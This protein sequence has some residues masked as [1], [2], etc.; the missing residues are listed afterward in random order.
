MS[1]DYKLVPVLYREYEIGLF[2]VLI[3]RP[4]FVHNYYLISICASFS[5]RAT[6]S[7]PNIERATLSGNSSGH[8]ASTLARRLCGGECNF[9]LAASLSL[10][11]QRR[12]CRGYKHIKWLNVRNVASK[13][14]QNDS[15]KKYFLRS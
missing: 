7:T 10:N 11:S 12:K 14:F 8:L 1:L 6:K 4:I 9:L 3:E 15:Q 13:L 2:P 5:N